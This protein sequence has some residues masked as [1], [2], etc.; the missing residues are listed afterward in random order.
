MKCRD[1][2]FDG[3]G[4][5]KIINIYFNYRKCFYVKEIRVYKKRCLFRIF[6]NELIIFIFK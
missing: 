5:Y 4:N 3:I 1:I 2:V 6:N